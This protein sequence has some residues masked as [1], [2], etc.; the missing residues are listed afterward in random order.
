LL[1][2]RAT[3]D[4]NSSPAPEKLEAAPAQMTFA[5]GKPITRTSIARVLFAG[6]GLVILFLLLAGFVGVRN[7][8]AMQNSAGE[9]LREQAITGDLLNE[10]RREQRALNAVY[11]KF[12]K[13]PDEIDREEVLNELDLADRALEGIAKTSESQPEQTTWK[14]L[15]SEATHFSKE[16]R[17]LLESSAGPYEPSGAL[18]KHHQKVL[19]LV[20]QLVEIETGRARVLKLQLDQ[21]STKLARESAILLGGALLLALL[22]AFYTMRQSNSLIRQLE[23]QAGELS[24]VSWH[25]LENQET[26][27]RRFSHEL[28][29]ELGQSLTAVKANLG[30][31]ASSAALPD[32]RVEDARRLVDEAIRN[33][34][35]LSQLL[36][37]T[38][39]DDFGLA[40]G[41]KWLCDGFRQRVQVE[42]EY[43]AGFDGRMADETETHLFRIA[44]E[45]LTNVARHSGATRVEVSL[46]RVNGQVHLRIAD[47][48]RGLMTSVGP[49]AGRS[50]GM[51]GMRARARNAGGELH[52]ETHPGNGVTIEATVPHR[53]AKPTEV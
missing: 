46:D 26:T 33:V 21:V 28:H 34:R 41:L 45:A 17:H 47:N 24:R 53:E 36:R 35:E 31:L 11:E 37:P 50:M 30:A 38:I 16:S 44:Q 8:R 3:G 32:E 42:V 5:L 18:Y 4:D 51:V 48:G 19:N 7:L 27:A 25:L 49:E 23:W 13:R 15:L 43:H 39:L 1:R 10:I 2:L 20:G 14:A 9:L 52:I 22:G 6:F 29:D 12:D 40:A